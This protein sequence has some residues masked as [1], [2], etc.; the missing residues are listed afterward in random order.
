MR[1]SRTVSDSVVTGARPERNVML[2][3]VKRIREAQ[4]NEGK[5]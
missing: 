5:E 4:F 1:Q 3:I 2:L